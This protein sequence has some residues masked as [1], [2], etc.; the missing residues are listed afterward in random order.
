MKRQTAEQRRAEFTKWFAAFGTIQFSRVERTGGPDAPLQVQ[1]K[2]SKAS[3]VMWIEIDDD[4]SKI[5]GIRVE[6][7]K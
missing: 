6:V 3:G 4:T 5:R 7:G 2:G 1:V